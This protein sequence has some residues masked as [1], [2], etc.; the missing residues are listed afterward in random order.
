[1]HVR[2]YGRSTRP[3]EMDE[4]PSSHAPLVRSSQA[5][6]DISTVVDGRKRRGVARV[7][8]FGWATGGQWAGYYASLYPENVSA[9]ILLNSLYR[10]N[11]QQPLIGRSTDSEDPANPGRF[12]RASCGAYRMNDAA[13]LLRPWNHKI[14]LADKS[15]WRDPAVT[16][17]YVAAALDNDPTTQ[18][19][20]PPSFRPPCGPMKHS[21]YLVTGRQ[22]WEA[23]L[24][25]APIF[26]S[27]PSH[28][29]SNQYSASLS[30]APF[31]SQEEPQC[32]RNLMKIA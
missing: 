3:K 13:S 31:D 14:P 12:N 18:S 26:P 30:G 8:L 32:P 6:H 16:Q 17:E 11:S 2:G 19:R 25:T 22:L 23:S 5:V 24:I 15:E 1:M 20:N 28:G 7:A 4:S 21:F 27:A 9:L 10:G 29:N